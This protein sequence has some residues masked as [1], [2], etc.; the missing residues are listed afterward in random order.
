MGPKRGI[1]ILPS[2]FTTGN[3]FCGF[4]AFVAVLNEQIYYAAVAITIGMIFDGL[5]GRISRW[6]S[7]TCAF[8]E[9]DDSFA[10]IITFCIAP[11]LLSSS[12][13][14]LYL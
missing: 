9:Q 4:Y 1:H 12:Q 7:T 5:V 6:T 3:V 11:A 8:G 2:L 10:D 14:L 13:S